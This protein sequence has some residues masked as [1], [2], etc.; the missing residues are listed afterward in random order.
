M[1]LDQIAE[2]K[3]KE[4]KRDQARWPLAAMKAGLRN[5]PPARNFRKAI[6]DGRC[7]IIAE[8]KRKSPSKGII[9]KNFDPL[10]IAQIYEE[11]GAAAVSVL[12]D[13]RFF[14]G[15]K[16]FLTR[17]KERTRLPILRKDFIIDPYQVYETK[18][19][20]GDA[21]LLITRLLG[22]RLRDY[23]RLA[24]SL[25]L[26]PFVEV[27]SPEDLDMALAAGADLIG[28]NNRDLMTF[29]TGLQTSLDLAPLIPEGKIVIA[30]SGIHSRKDVEIL[31]AAGI[32]AFLIGETLMKADDIAAKMKELMGP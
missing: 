2:A 3:K 5:P 13:Y 32:H 11:S 10:E 15:K 23:I 26:F 12:T 30:E 18:C 9:R 6:E 24:E 27:H 29:A 8:V 4:V 16:E 20:G 21:I 1:I 14:G 19:L 28:I 17:I 25:H 22:K 31:M 7:A